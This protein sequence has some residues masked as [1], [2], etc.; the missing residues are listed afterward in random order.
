MYRRLASGVEPGDGWKVVWTTRYPGF[1]LGRLATVASGWV[2]APLDAAARSSLQ[3]SGALLASGI[4][5]NTPYASVRLPT[6]RGD[7]WSFDQTSTMILED[8]CK[9]R[10]IRAGVVAQWRRSMAP[11]GQSSPRW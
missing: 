7:P 8:D 2:C 4:I 6:V 10:S 5:A 9:R 1:R 11:R 3:S